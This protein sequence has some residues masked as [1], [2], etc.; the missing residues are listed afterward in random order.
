MNA[1]EL[2]KRLHNGQRVFG[3]LVVS[4]SPL[5]PRAIATTG[6]DFVFIDTEH[7][8]LTHS[9][10]AAMFQSYR[11]VDLPP[12]VR[13]P[14]PD[15]I[16]AAK[17]LDI[18][19]AGVIAPYVET[20]EQA[21]DLVGAVRYR[22]IKG[23]RLAQRLAGESFEPELESYLDKRNTANVLVLNIESVP[24]IEA[25]PEILSVEGVDSVLI[26]PHDLSCSLG[27]PE[28]YDNANFLAACE[29][30]FQTAREHN[31]GAGI[32]FMGDVKQQLRFLE[33]GANMLIHSADI[34]LATK[35]LKSE[36][37]AIREAVGEQK[38]AEGEVEAI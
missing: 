5:W 34:V 16:A 3:T 13:I 17:M 2:R 19:A 27:I 24:A 6:L 31:V 12:I 29:K 4:E 28:D 22:P 20:P 14:C 21:T 15:P 11:G 23:K 1:S 8:A 10:V 32:H 26:G 7:T 36:L 9:Q 30:I 18:G 35:H 33:L 25:L 38:S 37:G